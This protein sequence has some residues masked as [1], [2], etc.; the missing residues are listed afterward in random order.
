MVITLIIMFNIFQ[1]SLIERTETEKKL[2]YLT[3]GSILTNQISKSYDD[4][5]SYDTFYEIKKIVTDTSLDVGGRI[6]VLDSAGK[7]IIDSNDA[8]EGHEMSNVPLLDDIFKGGSNAEIYNT[9]EYGKLLY[10]GVPITDASTNVVGVIMIVADVND[11]Y[12]E[13]FD[14]MNVILIVSGLIMITTLLIT[15]AVTNIFT[16]PLSKLFAGVQEITRGNYDYK[17]NLEASDEFTRLGNAFNMMSTRLHEVDDQ[18][19][20]FVSN[21]SHELRTP[22]ASLKIISESLLAARDTIDT[23]I[24]FEFLEDIDSET[25]RLNYIIDDLLY[26]VSIEKKELTLEYENRQINN[27]VAETVRR[28]RPLAGKRDISIFYDESVKIFAD[29]DYGKMTQVLM[30]V[31]GNA[32]KYNID[33]GEVD[34]DMYVD[35]QDR[36]V[37]DVIDTGIGIPEDEIMYVFDRFYRVD[38]ARS[39]Q[40][41][42]TGL[43]LSISKQIISLHLGDIEVMSVPEEGTTFRMTFPRRMEV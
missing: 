26:L 33:G 2:S 5:V 35:D 10:S 7:V 27:A 22:L 19:A 12:D 34:V 24:V 28:L 1:S 36:V 8:L 40:S 17:I 43:G 15:L 21:V 9:E 29:F 23:D 31:I 4:I 11:I 16:T 6:L 13:V 37:I 41:G 14:V 18:K 20:K 30:N 32:V 25:D 39:R 42:G 38:K 3:Q